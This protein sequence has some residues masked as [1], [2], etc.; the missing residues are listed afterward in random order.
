M[1]SQSVQQRGYQLIN[2]QSISSNVRSA[3]QRLQQLVQSMTVDSTQFSNQLNQIYGSLSDSDK[4][5]F[6]QIFQQLYGYNFTQYFY[7]RLNT[8]A[9][10]Q[11]YQ[12]YMGNSMMNLYQRPNTN[13]GYNS[14]MPYGQNN[15]YGNQNQQQYGQNNGFGYNQNNAGYPNQ[16]NQG[17]YTSM[18]YGT[19]YSATGYAAPYTFNSAYGKR[20][21]YRVPP[22]APMMPTP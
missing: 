15:M 8:Q 21:P 11:L 13:Q 2:Q 20:A 4:R 19:Q 17:G 1:T 14:N 12:Q 7:P 16:Q 22:M 6:E 9:F 3:W 18:A 5:Q 10:Q